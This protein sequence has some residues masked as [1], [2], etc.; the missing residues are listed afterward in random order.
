VEAKPIP[1][2]ESATRLAGTL[3]AF[4]K[5]IDYLDR[6]DG[7]VRRFQAAKLLP[8]RAT[9]E[10]FQQYVRLASAYPSHDPDWSRTT[11]I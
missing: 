1:A 7:F 5:L 8:E 4:R 11:T 3:R 2:G 6:M 10:L 9:A